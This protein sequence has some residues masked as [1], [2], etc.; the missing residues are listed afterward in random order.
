MTKRQFKP[1]LF[2]I[3]LMNVTPVI[4][5][6]QA[7][8]QAPVWIVFQEIAIDTAIDV[9]QDLF[10]DTVEPEEV[11]ALKQRVAELDAQL[12]EYQKQGNY[13]SLEEF[14]TVKQMISSV[15]NLVNSMANR[16]DSVERRVTQL[17]QDIALLRQALLVLPRKDKG[18][19]S[20]QDDPL[21]FQINY[22]YRLGGKG[23]FKP[24]GNGSVLHS[25][26]YYKII[27]TPLEDSYV[28]IFQVDSAKKLFRL[29]PIQGFGGVTVNHANPVKGG[30]TYYVPS[31]HQSFEL[32][33]QTGTETIYFIATRQN[34]IVLESQYQAFSLAEQ[35]NNI[36]QTQQAQVQLLNT[37][38]KGKGPKLRLVDDI[39]NAKTTW[40]E[41]GRHFS[42]LHQYLAEMCNAC[43]DILQFEHQ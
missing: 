13:P 3:F 25:G 1:A 36:A 4:S 5:A 15:S 19:K 14:N 16:L 17:E 9:V 24:I 29:F 7:A 30:K 33:A 28:Y 41:N 32:D 26:D 34:D 12:A 22:L 8:W 37:V 38:R 2:L 43:V 23:N 6:V 31:E 35:Q 18:I 40:Q 27:F 20:I 39:A 21:D 11:E 42:V 10:K